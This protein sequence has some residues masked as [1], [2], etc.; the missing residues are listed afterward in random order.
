MAR[1]DWAKL[2]DT[3]ERLHVW[4]G[5]YTFKFVVPTARLAET[6][7][8]LGGRPF[9]TRYSENGRWVSLSA[10][11]MMESAAEVVGVYRAVEDIPELISL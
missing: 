2:E 4:P 1:R 10:T 6:L 5:L 11:L 7:E 8:A 9:S 3:L